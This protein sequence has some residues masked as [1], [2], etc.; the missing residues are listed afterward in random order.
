MA[1][2]V[3]EIY[4]EIITQKE[5]VSSLTG[6]TPAPDT[7]QTF[8]EDL[9][10]TSK[11]AIWR[12]IC[13]IVAVA[14]WTHELLWDIFEAEIDA[15]IL[16]AIPGSDRWYVEM[17]KE[18]QYGDTQTWDGESYV[19]DPV[20]TTA[21]IIEQAAVQVSNGILIV[22]IAKSDGAS[23]LTQL[24]AA[25]EA[26]F[27]SYLDDNKFAGTLTRIINDTPDLLQL[28]YNVYVDN[29][30]IYNDDTNPA[31]PLNGSL[32]SDP[33]SFPVVDAIT[34]YIQTLDF[35]GIFRVVKLTDAIQSVTGV[36]NVVAVTVKAK[37]GGYAYTDILVLSD[38][39]YSSNAGYLDIDP[40]YPLTSEINYYNE[41]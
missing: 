21:Q 6:L 16:D 32:Y 15:K 1:R 12:L 22:K 26:A 20:D 28:E 2:T 24:S 4:D 9:T 18:F 10:S 33:T 40:V 35:N 30:I 14:V 34:D 3:N 17:I 7:A 39:A 27:E 13:W 19:Y 37:Y 41:S 31:D 29:S 8:L 5:S 36:T 25:E 23:G 11:V 38:Q